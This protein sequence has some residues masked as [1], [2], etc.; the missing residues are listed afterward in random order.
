MVIGGLLQI[1]LF[2]KVWGRTNDTGYLIKVKFPK[3]IGMKKIILFALMV[4]SGC[5]NSNQEYLGRAKDLYNEL[6]LLEKKHDIREMKD[7]EFLLKSDSILIEI[8][9]LARLL[10]VSENNL[11]S[12][13]KKSIFNDYNKRFGIWDVKY[14]VD[15]FGELTKERYVTNKAAIIGAFSNSATENS[16]L[17]VNFIIVNKDDIS[18]KLYEYARNNPVKNSGLNKV[19]VQDKDKNRYELIAYNHSDRL[20]FSNFGYYSKT[21]NELIEKNHS[22]AMWNILLKGGNIKFKIVED[23]YSTSTYNFSIE[24]ADSLFNSI[25]K[26]EINLGDK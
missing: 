6:I 26:A 5:V 18:I 19:Y 7:V 9:S 13:Y 4:L 11:L 10:K 24:N 2:F 12:N 16:T 25:I 15:A 14:F 3:T 22:N 20:S 1:I 17:A 8:D 21:G 23:E